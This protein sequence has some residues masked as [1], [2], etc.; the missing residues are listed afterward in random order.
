MHARHRVT[1]SAIAVAVVLSTFGVASSSAGAQSGVL[2]DWRMDESAGATTLIDSSGNGF[3]GVM[4]SAVEI[5]RKDG[6]STFHRWPY[7]SSR[8]LPVPAR[9][10]VMNQAALNPGTGDYAVEIRFRGTVNDGNITQKGQSG[11]SGGMWKIE[12]HSGYPTC[13]FR[14]SSGNGGIRVSTKVTDGKWHVLRCERRATQVVMVLDGV[15]V[16]RKQGA[17]GNISNNANVVI[18]GK[19]TCDSVTIECDYYRGDLDYVRIDRST[20]VSTTTTAAPTT[21]APT[22]APP[23]TA[24]PTTMPPTTTTTIRPTTTTTT[25]RPTTTTTTVAPTPTTVAPTVTTVV[26]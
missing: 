7:I 12:L 16:G 13:L 26:K 19:Q 21:A 1:A 18:G 6:S 23:T 15:I 24:P 9:L 2:A 5:G 22:T 25:I 8:A 20:G 4:G 17:T 14:G 11:N 3:H 10:H